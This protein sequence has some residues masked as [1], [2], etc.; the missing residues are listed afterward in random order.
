MNKTFLSLREAGLETGK[1]KM[2]IKRAIDSGRLSAVKEGNQWRIEPSE[3]FRVFPAI[4]RNDNKDETPTPPSERRNATSRNTDETSMLRLKL[5]M[6][7][8]QIQQLEIERDR[9]RQQLNERI[10]DLARRLDK[11]DGD[12]TRLTAVITDERGPAPRKEPAKR[13]FLSWLGR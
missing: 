2:T 11:A 9:E 4:S 7:D 10:E 1:D 5:E 8:N 13:G 3:L 6:R 12:R